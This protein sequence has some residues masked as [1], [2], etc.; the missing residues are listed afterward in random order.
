MVDKTTPEDNK[1]VVNLD[2]D[3]KDSKNEHHSNGNA[4]TQLIFNGR[5]L[6]GSTLVD[7]QHHHKIPPTMEGNSLT[8]DIDSHV[9]Q[10]KYN[11][12]RV[13]LD[14]AINALVD[15]LRQMVEENK[16][17]PVLYP[18]TD[19]D[20]NVLK[21]NIK[22]EHST[23]E[24][25]SRL[26][27]DSLA[28]LLSEKVTNVIR[29]LF[30]LKDRIDDTASKVFVTGDLN[31]GKSTFCNALLRRKILPED[32]QPCTNVFCE[33]IDPRDNNGLEEVHAVPIG[34]TYNIRDESTYQIFPISELESLVYKSSLYSILKIYVH[35]QRPIEQSLLKNGVVDISLIDAP[36]LN[37]DSYQTTQVFSRQEEIDLVV[38]VVNAADLFTLSGR[39]FITAA[40]NE[41]NLIFI[42]INKFDCIRDKQRCKERILNQISEL[43]PQT[44]KDASEFVHFVSSEEVVNGLPGPSDDGDENNG[45]DNSGRPD[46]DFDHLEA[47]LRKFV[48]EKRAVSKLL[49]AK[50]YLINLLDDLDTVFKLN[51]RLY[52]ENRNLL[53]SQL[54]EITPQYEKA[55]SSSS[56]ISGHIDRLIETTATECY[57][58]TRDAI[59]NTIDNI[60]DTPLIAFPGL[61]DM[62]RFTKETR[63]AL[64]EKVLGSV[65]AS[66]RFAR[67]K[68][69]ETFE[70]IRDVGRK[71]LDDDN[72]LADKSLRDDYMFTS[73]KHHQLRRVIDEEISIK[74]FFDPSYER[75]MQAI[76]LSGTFSSVSNTSSPSWWV[77]SGKQGQIWKNSLSAVAVYSSTKIF[78][79]GLFMVKN[80]VSIRDVFN[81]R[82]LQNVVTPLS[83]GMAIVSVS[84]L[85]YDIPTAFQRKSIQ[86]IKRHLG[87]TDYIHNNSSRV[88]KECTKVLNYASREVMNSFR[89]SID[90]TAAK[91]DKII[92]QL[93]DSEQSV[94]FY[95]RLFRSIRTQG[96]I[97]RGIKIDNFYS[98]VD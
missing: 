55:M 59:K 62:Y 19:N 47:S 71:A 91:K 88:S 56:K 38:F 75:F 76:G 70:I 16:S 95:H 48:L 69:L 83:I 20:L 13:A 37:L 66:E 49:P 87:S 67:Q 89:T 86:R 77:L 65:D 32:Q 10:L 39:E 26:N 6:E 14:R 92:S 7:G 53:L 58:F 63:M 82:F 9:Q 33:V 60:E 30:S 11:D 42:V 21:L 15:I 74:D 18:T 8:Q 36:G 45:P 43:S 79:N 68:T 73:K 35:D 93:K 84:Y 96:E 3:D 52:K 2:L 81:W 54:D 72:L 40:A 44:H 57:N 80:F 23:V 4:P 98:S 41:K 90:T 85:V 78:H 25:Y 50:T 17:R 94:Q 46:P 1:T 64:V 29:H 22:M 51:E 61:N 31:S 24:D 28:H 27:K 97:V 5:D 34:V 12:N